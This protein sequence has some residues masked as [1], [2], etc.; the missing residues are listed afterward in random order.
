M[1]TKVTS[2]YLGDNLVEAV[3]EASGVSIKMDLPV[4]NGGKGRNF[5]PTDLIGTSLAG[6]MLITM[7]IGA[8]KK[9]LD[10]QGTE[11]KFEKNMTAQPRKIESVKGT[12]KFPEHLS[13]EDK[14]YLMKFVHACPVGRT[15]EQGLE[16]VLEEI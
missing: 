7:A 5:S 6:C 16:I 3:H 13:A 10:V 11:I 2:R 1:G 4:D 14:E 8:R 15:L 9:D 12:I